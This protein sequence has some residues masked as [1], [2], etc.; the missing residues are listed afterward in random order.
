MFKQTF[1]SQQKRFDRLL[2]RIKNDFAANTIHCTNVDLMLA[3]SL[4]LWANIKS[5]L[6]QRLVSANLIVVPYNRV[7]LGMCGHVKKVN[8]HINN[9]GTPETGDQRIIYYYII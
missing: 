1:H 4:R 3:Y 7:C 5:T 8:K 6:V 9:H 2:I